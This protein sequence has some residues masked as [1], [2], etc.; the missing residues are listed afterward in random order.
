MLLC[1]INSEKNCGHLCFVFISN[2]KMSLYDACKSGNL[3]T[4]L[5]LISKGANDWNR[6][7]MGACEGGHLEIVNLMIS[8]GADNWNWGQHGACRGGHLE[9][10]NLMILKGANHWNLGLFW[11]CHM[12]YFEVAQL[13]ISKGAKY[14]YKDAKFNKYLRTKMFE[15]LVQLTNI[16]EDLLRIVCSYVL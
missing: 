15:Q 10:V 1:F 11:A 4:V 6:G 16:S 12:G 8:K 13:M 3:E 2:Q 14:D 7:L 5:D 9:I